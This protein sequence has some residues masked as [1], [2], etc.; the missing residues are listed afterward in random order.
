VLRGTLSARGHIAD[1]IRVIY[2]DR[3]SGILTATR[4]EVEKRLYFEKGSFAFSDTTEPGWRLGDLLVARG[5]IS[6]QDLGDVLALTGKG[7]RIGK[8]LLE[9]GLVSGDQLIDGVRYQILENIYPVFAWM[10]GA[11]NF[12]ERE[13]PVPEDIAL[14][15]S[16]ANVVMEGVRR[17]EDSEVIRACIGSTAR[18]VVLGSNPLLRFQAISLKPIEGF[19]LS[20]IDGLLTIEEICS[21]SPVPEEE[22]LK[23]LYGLHSAGILDLKTREEHD[24][25]GQAEEQDIAGFFTELAGLEDALQASGAVIIERQELSPEEERERDE[26]L[27]LYRKLEDMDHHQVLGVEPTATEAAVRKAYYR[28][29]KKF[30]PDRHHKGGLIELQDKLEAIFVRVNEAYEAMR[31]GKVSSRQR[32]KTSATAAQA[33]QPATGA[34]TAPLSPAEGMKREEAAENNYRHGRELFEQGDY[35]G[36]IQA[37][38][39][40]VQ[41]APDKVTYQSYLGRALAKNPKWRRDAEA[42]LLKAVELEPSTAEHYAQLGQLYAAAGL[43][44]KAERFFAEALKW[45]SSNKSALAG[46]VVLEGRESAGAKKKGTLGGLFDRGKK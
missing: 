2:T 36:A 21:I 45:D 4:G 34:A 17:I 20:R 1:V 22:T 32:K 46:R 43:V 30:H 23:C 40:A 27:A 10:E 18:V 24:A 37:F 26:V 6:A 9:L 38:R 16:T 5:V 25:E 44:N 14:T 29:A 28:L 12:E 41:I 3:H 42:H 31:E 33:G 19:V 35:F 13:H 39:T 7:K 11:Y 15:L 8:I